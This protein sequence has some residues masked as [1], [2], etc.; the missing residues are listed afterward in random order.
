LV[1]RRFL[2]QG[3]SSRLLQ[4]VLVDLL[5]HAA[6]VRAVERAQRTYARR[7]RSV[8]DALGRAGV[9]VA[10]KDGLNIWLPVRDESAALLRLATHGVG[11]SAGGPFWVGPAR[12]P[13]LRVTVGLVRTAHRDVAAA[14]AAAAAAGARPAPR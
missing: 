9:A 2:G 14:L 12:E 13:H 3:W 1:D 10:G 6:S 8:V 11:A 4:S 5:T 7:R